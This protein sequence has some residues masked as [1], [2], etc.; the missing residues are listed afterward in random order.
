MT[1]DIGER[2][3]EK[4]GARP[5]F[6]SFFLGQKQRVWTIKPEPFFNGRCGYFSKPMP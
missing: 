2:S 3:L 5:H 6:S 4:N 1:I